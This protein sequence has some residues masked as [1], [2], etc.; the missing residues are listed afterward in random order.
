MRGLRAERGKK[1]GASRGG[2]AAVRLGGG[3]PSPFRD[4]FVV[5]LLPN[6]LLLPP[7][8]RLLQPS[9]F[10]LEAEEVREDWLVGYCLWTAGGGVYT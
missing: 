5:V 7:T 3:H 10:L 9:S 1:G 2:G 6:R 8:V 4:L